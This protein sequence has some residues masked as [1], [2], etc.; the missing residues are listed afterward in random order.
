MSVVA[1]D[2]GLTSEHA[3]STL[4]RSPRCRSSPYLT[5]VWSTSRGK[6]TTR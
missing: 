6:Q 5:C 2:R 4:E 1:M 3:I